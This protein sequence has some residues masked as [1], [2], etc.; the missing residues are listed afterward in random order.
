MKE[1]LVDLVSPTDLG[2]MYYSRSRSILKYPLLFMESTINRKMDYAIVINNGNV[3][4]MFDN[5]GILIN[6]ELTYL[7]HAW[8]KNRKFDDELPVPSLSADLKLAGVRTN[9]KSMVRP[10]FVKRDNG[11][12]FNHYEFEDIPIE[13]CT[14]SQFTFAKVIFDKQM[15]SPKWVELSENCMALVSENYLKGFFINLRSDS[16]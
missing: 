8:N 11:F 5:S 9:R 7:H 13:F 6:V 1:I 2:R 10:R 12:T 16:D 14:D 4:L 3:I 15:P